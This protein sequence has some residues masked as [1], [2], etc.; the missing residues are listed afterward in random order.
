MKY[1]VI[2]RTWRSF[3]QECP[4]IFPEEFTHPEMFEAIRKGV[5]DMED[6]ELVSAGFL[7]IMTAL[8]CYGMSGGLK[9]ASRGAAD[10][11]LIREYINDRGVVG[12]QTE[13]HA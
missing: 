3:I 4:V 2:R 7:D 8:N 10:T 6:A 13:G 12:W 11:N 9:S 1:I 5:E